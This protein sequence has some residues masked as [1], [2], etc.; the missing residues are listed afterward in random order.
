MTQ[1]LTK[2]RTATPAKLADL[3]REVP[4][5]LILGYRGERLLLTVA[6]D[7]VKPRAL[8][9]VKQLVL[10]GVDLDA[11]LIPLVRIAM[12][13]RHLKLLKYLCYKGFVPRDV[14]IKMAELAGY[15]P[16]INFLAR[17]QKRRIAA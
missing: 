2:A 16:V 15:R 8:R 6:S 12:K 1:L 7:L 3:V 11:V 5:A 9:K 13:T 14:D 10:Y 4:A 17:L